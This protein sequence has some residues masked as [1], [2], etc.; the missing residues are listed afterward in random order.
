MGR[1]LLQHPPPSPQRHGEALPQ[2]RRKKALRELA[3]RWADRRDGFLARNRAFHDDEYRYLRFL[4]PE[5][6]KVL[7][8]GCGTG[9]LLSEIRPARGVGV[10]LSPRM[11]EIARRNFPHLEFV[12][13][14]IEDPAV[15]DTLEGPFDVIV[16]ADT[17][18]M[19]E[20]CQSTLASLHRLCHT[21]TSLI[22]TYHNYL[23]EPVL[24]LA[25]KAG[26][27]LPEAETNWLR[28]EDIANLVRLAD[29]EPV[30]E[31]WRQLV[32]V[33]LFGLGR[34]VNRFLGTLPGIRTLCLRNY[35]VARPR[36]TEPK[37]ESATVLV[38]CRN[39]RGNIEAIVQ[40]LPAFCG[41]IEILFVEGNS[42][43]GTYEE[44]ERVMQAYPDRDI[45]VLRQDGRGKGDAV[46]KGF[47][48]AS[49]EVL[50]ILDADMTVPPE[51][52]PKFFEALASGKGEF[53]NGSRLVYPMEQDAMRLLNRIANHGFS[54]LFTWLL[55]QRFTDTLCGTKVL[56]KRH[57]DRIA[58]NRSYF[59]DFDP[60]G[61][62]DLIFGASKL[63]LKIAEIP[64]RYAARVY[65]ETQI[66]R[67]RHGWLLL[68]MVVFAYFKLKAM[69]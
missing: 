46:R 22:I 31:D 26:L 57:Y 39:E 10:D 38:P 69:P 48:H 11:I 17:I 43:D 66:S 18:G 12:V 47:A 59:G 56:R 20:D 40:R 67:F 25:E 53:I 54:V 55:N 15:L 16:L 60:F 64:I 24:S 13:G 62:F 42:R 45:K 14:D 61:D 35:L 9:R 6:L 33:S 8:V 36:F 21:D 27:R 44:I 4:I 37:P 50:M 19:L 3:D 32:P 29:F 58:A 68:R 63:N 28:P 51:D 5:G 65:G 52:L 7:E 41:H 23:W 34:L 2:Q 1:P 30:R 49:G